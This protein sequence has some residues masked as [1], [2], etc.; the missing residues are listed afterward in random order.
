M[1]EERIA[2][3]QQVLKEKLKRMDEESK[4]RQEEE[5]Q[6]KQQLLEERG[7]L[8]KRKTRKEAQAKLLYVVECFTCGLPGIV[9]A[10]GRKALTER[11]INL[12]LLLQGWIW[13]QKGY[14]CPGCQDNWAK[15]A[16]DFVMNMD[17]RL[18]EGSIEDEN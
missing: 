1:D 17:Q 15:S 12:S 16:V 11:E 2:E 4:E 10:V 18:I 3:T 5:W 14:E 6:R 9:Q 8:L 13:G 7:F